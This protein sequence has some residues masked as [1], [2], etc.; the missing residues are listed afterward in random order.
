MKS[1]GDFEPLLDMYNPIGHFL[2]IW[3]ALVFSDFTQRIY[4]VR[5]I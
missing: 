4:D 1:L 3:D 2:C 5:K